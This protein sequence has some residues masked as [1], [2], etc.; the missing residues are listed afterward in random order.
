M[1]NMFE[2][3]KT[4][5]KILIRNTKMALGSLCI[6]RNI[7]KKDVPLKMQA[8]LEKLDNGSQDV[9]DTVYLYN[10][11]YHA[12]ASSDAI[13]TGAVSLKEHI[14]NL[15]LAD[16]N[17][18]TTSA[19]WLEPDCLDTELKKATIRDLSYLQTAVNFFTFY[20]P[21]YIKLVCSSE[22][23]ELE[24]VL[25]LPAWNR[26]GQKTGQ[27]DHVQNIK[28]I[29][30]SK[31]W[32][33]CFE[34]LCLFHQNNGC[35]QFALYKAFVWER[36]TG[37][38]HGNFKGVT[39]PDTISLSD[40]IGYEEQRSVVI[41][42]TEKF[43]KGY[44][45]NNVLLYGDRGTGKSSTVK[46]ILNEYSNRGL[47]LVEV[48]KNL[49][50][51]F[52]QIVSNL[53]RINLKFIVF[54]D[55]LAFEDNEENYTALKAALEGSIESKPANVLIYATSNRRHLI[56]EKFSDRSGLQSVNADDEIRATDSIQE[57][58][59]L[60]DRFGIT[61]VFTSP[62][63]NNFL[64]IVDGLAAKRGLNTDMEELHREALK[65]ELW[66]NGRSPRTACQFIDWF[67]GRTE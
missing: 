54:V 56:K 21:D 3:N 17:P 63:K 59:S 6:Y 37:N 18:F 27:P 29:L 34:D 36:N 55:D 58:L 11:L 7:L 51:D 8:F 10:E 26:P 42:N 2:N 46:A 52:P 35:G 28:K 66:Y 47:R 20:A 33:E 67:S 23:P 19:Q 45:S 57:K 44:P 15:M 38:I 14:I 9:Y 39:N 1:K 61:V 49:L 24:P 64:K 53:K 48:P 50:M 60:A 32:K 12:L 30:H 22:Y 31:D 43:L 4:D 62:D 41:D 5:Y 25:P 13:N 16:E 65:W 40:F